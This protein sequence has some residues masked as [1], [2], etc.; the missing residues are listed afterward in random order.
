MCARPE[1]NNEIM[2]TVEALPRKSKD[3]SMDMPSDFRASKSLV[4]HSLYVKKD[5][6]KRF[7]CQTGRV[8]RRKCSIFSA[9]RNYAKQMSPFDSLF[10][11]V[12]IN[13]NHTFA[14]CNPVVK[15]VH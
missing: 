5:E 14:P 8:S 6:P 12:I 15:N 9:E 7:Q 2:A 13:C 10:K 1:S 3:L 4:V 11:V